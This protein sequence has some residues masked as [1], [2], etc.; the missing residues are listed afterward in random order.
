M[1]T[2]LIGLGSNL[3]DRT[4]FLK[5]AIDLLEAHPAVQVHAVSR[6]YETH[7][8]GGPA[9]QAS[10]QNAAVRIATD[11]APRDLFHFLR[12]IED[13]LG[14]ARH[15]RWEARVIDIDL[16]MYDD[17]QCEEDD[18]IVPHPRMLTRRF[19]LEPAA[20]V[21][22]QLI[23]PHTGW[24][25]ARHRDHLDR[26]DDYYALALA[27]V[28]ADRSAV[29]TMVGSLHGIFIGDPAARI[30]RGAIST[31]GLDPQTILES[32]RLRGGLAADVSRLA[33]TN[34]VVTDFWFGDMLALAHHRLTAADSAQ[35]A[36]YLKQNP[37]PIAP[38]LRVVPAESESGYVAIPLDVVG[39]LTPSYW[40]TPNCPTLTVDYRDS[41]AM[42]AE[43]SAA[44]QG[45]Q[46]PSTSSHVRPD[47]DR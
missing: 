40:E 2:C 20:E 3:G 10:Y 24:T 17:W 15:T 31:S 4:S 11:L 8:I 5:R 14:R 27:S 25:I 23:H 29:D 45:M 47:T 13:R 38:K 37:W 41:Q 19:V 16:L 44:I 35:V 30:V 32:L 7:P 33:R 26:C 46:K 36:G 28:L 43:I 42:V 22:P 21:A 34:V 6:C 18:L 1:P 9:G 39:H 12:Q